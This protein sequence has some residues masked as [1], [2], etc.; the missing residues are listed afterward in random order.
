MIRTNRPMAD[1]RWLMV[2]RQDHMPSAIRYR[3]E[4]ELR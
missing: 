2:G 4:A 3:R 1:G